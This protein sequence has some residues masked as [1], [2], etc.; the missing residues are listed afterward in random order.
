MKSRIYLD[1]AATTPVSDAARA[2]LVEALGLTGNPSSVH[3]G[4]RAANALLEG[5]RDT[6]A[7][8]AGVAVENIVFTSGG[9]EAIAL[10][11]NGARLA[12]SVVVNFEEGAELSIA[13]GD[14]RKERQAEH[15]GG[16]AAGVAQ[17]SR[18][19]MRQRG[20]L[21]VH[22]RAQVGQR[23]GLGDI[24]ARPD[25]RLREPVRDQHL[26]GRDRSSP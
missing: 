13:D 25:P 20:E 1:H 3:G 2:A 16:R 11:S 12:V 6:V 21:R 15:R 17:L 10:A 19:G 26:I 18:D 8:F 7:R 5:A 9:T 23:H 22:R 24:G 14:E 4:G